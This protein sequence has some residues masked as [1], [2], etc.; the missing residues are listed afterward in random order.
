MRLLLDSHVWLWAGT[1]PDRI[2]P[3]AQKSIASPENSLALSVAS[4]WELAIKVSANRLTVPF[5]FE[6]WVRARLPAS[7]TTL[8][9][10]SLDHVFA[11]SSL[12]DHHRDPFD[13]MLVAQAQVEGM[14]L[15]TADQRLLAYP[16]KSMDARL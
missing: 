12:P 14:T 5:G 6:T 16:V 9:G 7:Q 8:L 13:R 3:Q 10:I 15:V 1:A 4:I 11:V 2:G